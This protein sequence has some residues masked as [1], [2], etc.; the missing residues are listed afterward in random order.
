MRHED[1]RVVRCEKVPPGRTNASIEGGRRFATRPVDL[2]L[3]GR[4]SRGQGRLERRELVERPALGDPEV[5]L[6]PAVVDDRPPRDRPRSRWLSRSRGRG[7]AGWTRPGSRREC[8]RELRC[9]RRGGGQA[10]LVERRV[11]PPAVAVS[12]PCGRGVP[13]EDEF[14]RPGRASH[15]L[16]PAGSRR[17]GPRPRSRPPRI[18]TSPSRR[19]WPP[20]PTSVPSRGPRRS[21]LRAAGRG[22]AR[23]PGRGGRG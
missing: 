17:P 10:R 22:R 5:G 19:G 11:A 3:A 18:R 15:D 12:G 21:P 1:R 7:G 8:R 20:R 14:G 6:A 23:V 16:R 4:E 2:G 9:Q 13:D